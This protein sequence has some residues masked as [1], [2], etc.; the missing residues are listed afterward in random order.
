[1][2][3][4]FAMFNNVFITVPVDYCLPLFSLSLG[5]VFTI[6]ARFR[7]FLLHSVTTA[8]LFFV[9]CLPRRNY[10]SRNVLHL[11]LA[12]IF[13]LILSHDSLSRALLL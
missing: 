7:F 6:L 10:F 5:A 1:M 3:L 9:Y 8:H 11:I 13:I 12:P 2:F 4:R